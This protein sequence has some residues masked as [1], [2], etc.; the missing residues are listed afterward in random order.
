MKSA[1]RPSD[2]ALVMAGGQPCGSA[3]CDKIAVARACAPINVTAFTG[4]IVGAQLIVELT[5]P[6]YC[7]LRCLAEAS[8]ALAGFASHLQGDP[9]DDIASWQTCSPHGMKRWV[10][11]PRR[12]TAAAV[13]PFL[14]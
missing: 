8:L 6:H 7:V 13:I 14:R 9:G 4:I 2:S 1:W 11:K 12:H 10:R 3:T 5:R